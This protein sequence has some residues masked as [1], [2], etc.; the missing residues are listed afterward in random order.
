MP[1]LPEVETMVRGIRPHVQG[2]TLIRFRRTPC[3]CRPILVA[4]EPSLISRRAARKRV[5]SVWRRAKRVILELETGDA[6][7]IEPRMTGLML[8]SDPPDESHLRAEWILEAKGTQKHLWFWD[9]RGLGTVR[10]YRRDDL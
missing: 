2:L 9:R 4:P 5:T 7:V 8:V 3:S 6:F 1:E 10:F